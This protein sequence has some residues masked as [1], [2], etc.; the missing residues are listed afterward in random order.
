M[1]GA[2]F[3]V[4]LYGHT[5]DDVESFCKKLAAVLMIEETEAM[6]LLHD[7]PL[8][9]RNNMTKAAAEN[10]TEVL[11]SIRALSIAEPMDGSVIETKPRAPGAVASSIP[12]TLPP[13]DRREDMRS[14][15]WMFLGL[16]LAGF[17]VVSV[18][19]GVTASYINLYKESP[20]ATRS[21]SPEGDAGATEAGRVDE[22]TLADLQWKVD[23]LEREYDDLR[24]ERDA[25]HKD[26]SVADYRLR[27]PG[28]M[29]IRRARLRSVKADMKAVLEELVEAKLQLS[30]M[31]KR[32]GRKASE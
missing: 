7:V 17:L 26:V 29:K 20:S 2:K 3:Q 24:K 6:I 28:E 9:V 21:P 22:D 5:S 32:S 8:I 25:A 31:R 13:V 10:L 18:I 14:R 1:S 12:G 4:K 15:A 11:T 30:R 16:G 27:I 23:K 19:I